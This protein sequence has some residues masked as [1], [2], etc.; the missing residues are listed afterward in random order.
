MQGDSRVAWREG[1]FLRQQHFQQQDR[2]VES[3]VAART[4]GLRPYPWGVIELKIN[5]DLAALGKF[6]IEH[7][8]GVH[9]MGAALGNIRLAGHTIL[10]IKLTTAIIYI[11]AMQLS[12]SFNNVIFGSENNLS[13]HMA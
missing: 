1:L 4:N 5:Q 2:Y 10:D 3:M 9:L 8:V 6:A 13:R 12:E 7:L 11:A